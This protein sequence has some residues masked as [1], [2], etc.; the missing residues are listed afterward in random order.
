LV[1]GGGYD[2]D[3]LVA[4]GVSKGFGPSRGELWFRVA[5][6]LAGLGLVVVAVTVKEITGPAWIE[7][8]GLGVVFFGGSAAWSLWKLFKSSD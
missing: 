4:F 1:R 2:L 3:H 6:S 8:V 5:L 7:V